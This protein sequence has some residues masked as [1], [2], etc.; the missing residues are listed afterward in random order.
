MTFSIVKV[1]PLKTQFQNA[2]SPIWSQV[3]LSTNL[4]V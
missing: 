2:Y 1:F 3:V 4:W